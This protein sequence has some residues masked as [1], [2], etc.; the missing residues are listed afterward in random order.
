M[1]KIVYPLAEVMRIKEKRVEDAER[2]LQE[3]RE[4]LRK[5]QEKLKECERERDKVK[6][7]LNDKL[8]Q[9]RR[10]LDRGTTSPKIRQMKDYM[11]LVKENL[12]AEE[13]KVKKQKE[14]VVIAED[15]VA[16]AEKLLQERR[17]EVDKL[18]EH[19]KDWVKTMRKEIAFEEQKEQD[20]IGNITYTLHQRKK[21]EV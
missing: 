2:E 8:L 6:E 17:K 20:E 19:K 4:I 7:H 18:D 9:L 13:E 15:N 3:K 16:L 21:K 11:N 5:E 1:A 12:A 10:E 14:Q